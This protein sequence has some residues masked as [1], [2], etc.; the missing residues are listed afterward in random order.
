M[1]KIPPIKAVMT[2]FP[3]SIDIDA[4]LEDARA[5]MTEH[6]IRHLPVVEDGELCGML[7]ERDMDRA[8][9]IG[10]MRVREVCSLRTYCVELHEPV[11]H[12]L[13]KMAGEH[14]GSAL[15]VRQGKLVGIFTSTD[16]CRVFAETLETLFPGP[17]G[18]DAA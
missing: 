8:S 3:Y 14:V 10:P 1:N 6:E 16:A 17:G 2:P 12:V 4:T 5:L 18:E 15:V 11:N 13:R 9:S 7:S